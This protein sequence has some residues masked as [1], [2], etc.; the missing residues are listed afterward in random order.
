[1]LTNSDKHEV[2]CWNDS[3]SKQQKHQDTIAQTP[4]FNAF[5]SAQI[6][7]SFNSRGLEN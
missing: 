2:R 6:W 3:D 7:N 4:V 5:V 1:M